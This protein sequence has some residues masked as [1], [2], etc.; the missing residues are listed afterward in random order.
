MRARNERPQVPAMIILSFAVQLFGAT[1]LLLF[2]VRMVSTG[3][4]RAYGASFRR[5]VTTKASA[6]RLALT[7]VMLAIILQSSA[8]VTLLVAGFSGTSAIGFSAGMAIVLGGDLGSAL[9]IRVLTLD[10]QWIVPVLL[11]VGGFLFLKTQGPALKQA[12]RIAMGIALILIAL[13]FLRETMDPIRESAFLPAIAGYLVQDYLTAF[14]TGVALA[15]VMHSSVAVI[16]ICVTLV[17]IGALPQ[18]VGVS[19]VLGANLGSALIPVWLTRGMPAKSRRIPLANLI[20]RG[21]VSVIVLLAINQLPTP[22]FIT[23][24]DNA[25]ALVTLHIL[26]NLILLLSLPFVG[27]LQVLVTRIYP[28]NATPANNVP[29]HHHSVLDIN[30]TASPKQSLAMLQREVLRMATLVSEMIAPAFGLLRSF[31]AAQV[32]IIRADEA[33]LNSALDHIRQYSADFDYDSLTK[34]ENKKMRNLVDYAISLE[35]A[36]DIVVKRLIE[37]AGEKDREKLQFSDAGFDE[38]RALHERV[39][40]NVNLATNVLL[41]ADI[42]SA[43]LLLEEKAEI[44]QLERSSRKKHLRRL[45]GGDADSLASSDIHLETA[46]SLKEFHSWIVKIAHPILMRE[47]Q[48]LETRLIQKIGGDENAD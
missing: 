37:L 11:G 4:E 33:A 28:D 32:A 42:E 27:R 26:F 36:G 13:R 45:S 23:A 24:M 34:S 21:T 46:Y 38:L 3:I 29:L 47:G 16:L 19:L 9:L 20:I 22:S 10:I 12:G 18:S 40:R 30:A 2:A 31:D 1:M 25:H 5:L 7:G 15:F 41:S 48:L 44:A 17:A 14:I 39:A 35:A 43:R 6:L 8:A